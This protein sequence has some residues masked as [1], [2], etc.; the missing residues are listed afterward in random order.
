MVRVA[1]TLSD[2]TR[3]EEAACEVARSRALVFSDDSVSKTL[4]GYTFF[5]FRFLKI[6]EHLE[7][8]GDTSQVRA[9]INFVCRN[10]CVCNVSEAG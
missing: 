6:S 2:A 3:L 5:A 4:P 1:F 8:V 9:S 7:N 10:H